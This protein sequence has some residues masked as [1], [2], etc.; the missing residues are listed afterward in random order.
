MSGE[1]FTPS[2]IASLIAKIVTIEKKQQKLSIYDPTCGSGS[3]L[4]KI[5]KELKMQN[6][7][8]K[9]NINIYGQELNSTT[10]NLARM[11][12]LLHEC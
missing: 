8:F 10:Y 1:F 5:V 12:M 6:P 2:S 9:K 4:L 11:N 7:T 3:L